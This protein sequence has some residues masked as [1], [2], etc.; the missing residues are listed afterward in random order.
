MFLFQL[1]DISKALAS[2]SRGQSK[3]IHLETNDIYY[4]VICQGFLKHLNL[5]ISCC[6][7]TIKYK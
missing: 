1:V 7:R 6:I 5:C 3:N 2:L 4:L